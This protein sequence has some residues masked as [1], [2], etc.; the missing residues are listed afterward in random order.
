MPKSY[1]NSVG[2]SR[3]QNLLEYRSPKTNI[4]NINISFFF[5]LSSFHNCSSLAEHLGSTEGLSFAMWGLLLPRFLSLASEARCC[6][7]DLCQETP[8]HTCTWKG[9]FS[10]LL[11]NLQISS[12]WDCPSHC[13]S[14]AF[15]RM[16]PL[17]LLPTGFLFSVRLTSLCC[18]DVEGTLVELH[19]LGW[20]KHGYPLDTPDHI[21]QLQNHSDLC[22]LCWL[23]RTEFAVKAISSGLQGPLPGQ[24][25]H[26]QPCSQCL[27]C[28]QSNHRITE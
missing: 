24:Q 23:K 15:P 11:F 1:S 6:S 22:A 25:A 26:T 8:L 13:G 27:D 12:L 16:V 19:S 5:S 20:I 17:Q 4:W 14:P 21:H 3:N 28:I 18:E 2:L 9:Y 7:L 10:L